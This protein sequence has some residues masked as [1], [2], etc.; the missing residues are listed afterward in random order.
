MKVLVKRVLPVAAVLGAA[1]LAAAQT[2]TLP[3][4]GTDISDVT[5]NITALV[6]TWLFPGLLLVT[7][8]AMGVYLFKA[9]RRKFRFP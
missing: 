5:A 6:T 7:V 2:V 8:V 4:V 9:I 3:D 1:S